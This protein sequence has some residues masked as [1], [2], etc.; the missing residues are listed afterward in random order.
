MPA[1]ELSV[2]KL[3]TAG[4]GQAAAG[5]DRI[6]RGRPDARLKRGERADRTGQ[7]L[8]GQVLAGGI[9]TG[10][11]GGRG[12]AGGLGCCSSL[13]SCSRGTHHLTVSHDGPVSTPRLV[14]RW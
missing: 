4:D 3:E 1:S 5:P 14:T 9:L 7:A 6:V 8:L 11:A 12:T 10:W 13:R 2:E